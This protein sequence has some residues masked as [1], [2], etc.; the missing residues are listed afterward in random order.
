MVTLAAALWGTGGAAA[1]S[2]YELSSTNPQSVAF[3]RMLLSV[4]VLATLNWLTLGKRAFTFE[5]RDLKPML[6]AGAL[7]AVYQVFYFAAIPRIGVAIATLIAL[8]AAPVIV[9]VLSMFARS[10][11]ESPRPIVWVALVCSIVGA[12]LLTQVAETRLQNEWLVGVLF[13]LASATL[14]ASNTFVGR[15][16]GSE[17]RAHPL[18]L[19]TIGFA[20]GAVVLFIVALF[21]GLQTQYPPEGWA[22]LFYLGAFPTAIAYA[23]FY[24]GMKSINASVA[25]I[26][27]LLEP[28]TATILAVAL[29]REP[30]SDRAVLGSALL[31]VAM[32]ILIRDSRG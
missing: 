26:A 30:L 32:L 31:I 24:T 16:L 14:Y 1:K 21:S 27:T 10:I 17:G 5:R 13:A 29:F 4:P 9:A 8:C 3:F 22:R 2:I 18:Q 28:L 6:L 25:S 12:F 19:T 23:L 20:F 15:K 7:V 11:R